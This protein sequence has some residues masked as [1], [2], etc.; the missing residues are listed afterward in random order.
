MTQ[1]IIRVD[2]TLKE[3][4]A[5]LSRNEGKTTSQLMREM[6]EKYVQEH[7]FSTYVDHVWD[8]ISSELKKRGVTEKDLHNSIKKYR[9]EKKK[10]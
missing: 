7:D 1:I 4:F 9:A 6:M 5:R 10:S 3:N 2:D 8:T